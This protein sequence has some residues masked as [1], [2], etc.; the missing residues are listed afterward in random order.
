M[1]Q[2][3]SYLA[4]AL[5]LCLAVPAPAQITAG[6]TSDSQENATLD[7]ATVGASVSMPIGNGQGVVAMDIV[8]LSGSGATVVVERTVGGLWSGRNL[9]VVGS[10]G[11]FTGSIS[12]DTSLTLNSAG[13]RAIRL[14]VTVAGTGLAR[15]YS[16]ATA[17]SSAI[18]FAT[19]LPPGNNNI[20]DIDVLTMPPVALAPGSA[21]AATQ[22][23]SWS[24][25][26]ASSVPLQISN[27]PSSFAVSNFPAS[28][29]V[30]GTFW[31]ATQPVSVAATVQV[32]DAGQSLTVDSPQI[33]ATLGPKTAATSLSV[34]P[35]TDTPF[36]IY[37][38]GSTSFATGQVSVG[39]TPTLVAAARPGRRVIVLYP[40]NN[41]TYYVSGTSTI[42]TATSAPLG[43]GVTITLPTTSAVY[44]Q[45]ASA[46]TMGYVEFYQ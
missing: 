43:G 23:G 26:L 1:R 27:F 32:G 19:S 28:Q 9:L 41:T 35:N 20:G 46:F 5:A 3:L 6:A 14:R 18:Q 44:A 24:F 17:N 10:A 39:T 36:P 11:A 37:D 38:R 40:T 22:S 8:G 34:A 29:A 31:Q 16:N 2:I 7:L 4:A 33:P 30:T 45:G 15:I 21:V 13:S 25:N 12:A 42:V